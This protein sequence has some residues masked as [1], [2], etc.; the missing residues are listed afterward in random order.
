MVEFAEELRSLKE[1]L[2]FD[3]G[4]EIPRST[5]NVVI[6]GM[7]GSG[8]VGR[9][10]SELYSELQITVVDDYTVPEFA[11]KETLCIAISYSGK[12]EETISSLI[13][14]K[15]KGASTVAISSGRKLQEFAD[16][17]ITVPGGLQP[18]SALG[19]MLMPLVRSFGAAGEKEI[20]EAYALLDRKDRENGDEERMARE[21]CSGERIPIV[22]G[23]H[24]YKAVAY[25]W[26]SQFNENAKV[27]ACANSFP[28]LNH[29][30]TMALGGTYR[31]GEFYF[32]SFTDGHNRSVERR[33]GITREITGTEFRMVKAE[34]SSRFS[35][36][37]DLVHKGDYVSYHLA[38]CRKADPTDVSVIERLKERLATNV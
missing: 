15:S 35:R 7:G 32:I 20:G 3:K 11:S 33:I 24:P 37:M 31:K 29:N 23:I 6:A 27:L 10:F 14:A 1:Q 28:E 22:Y 8:V 18:R 9:I 25:R 30:E 5:R 38:L 34:G 21:I 19:Y 13:S 4:F 17:S 2:G 12:T 16:Q 26:K 36:V